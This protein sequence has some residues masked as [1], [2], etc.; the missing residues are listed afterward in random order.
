MKLNEKR[1]INK[2]A[3]TDERLTIV[4]DKTSVQ[5]IIVALTGRN[6]DV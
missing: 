1:G 3:Y 4:K 6:R 5:L 2:G